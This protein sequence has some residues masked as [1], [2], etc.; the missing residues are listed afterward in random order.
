MAL[1]VELSTNFVTALSG[2]LDPDEIILDQ[3]K[4][5]PYLK[6][7][8]G[9]WHGK[10]AIMVLPNSTEKL[11]KIVTLC[12]EHQIAITCQG[13]NTGLVGGQIPQGEL[14][15]NTARMSAVRN[16]D[17][18]A[19]TI[20][21]EAGMTLQSVTD[22]CVEHNLLFAL[23]IASGGSATIGGAIATNAGGMGVLRYGNMRAMV[24]G[25]EVVM[26]D[27]KVWHGL[28]GLHKD[29]TGYDLKQLFI[30]S[31]GT[32]GVITAAILQLFPKP[33]NIITAWCGL[34]NVEAALQLLSHLRTNSFSQ[35]SKFELISKQALS[36]VLKNLSDS[37]APF[38]DAHAYN[39]LV[40]FETDE[41]V[42]IEE[43]LSLALEIGIITDAV[44]A[45][46]QKEA[47]A[48]LAL[49]ENIS[50]AQKPE[51]A[52]IKHDISLPLSAIPQF[53]Q[54]MQMVISDKFPGTRFCVFGHLGDGNLHYNLLQP[55]D[56]NGDE[57]L[58]ARDQI[59]SMVHDLVHEMGGSF[60]AEHGIGIAK[61]DDM[62][63]YK[64]PVGLKMM[65]AVKQA[66]DPDNIMNPRVIFK[67]PN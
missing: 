64:S 55:A 21:V 51:G 46:S 57:F 4:L 10:T 49:R 60:A 15:L 66:I 3:E 27:G 25:L 28:S 13:G 14:L 23:Q 52:A 54:Q 47:D 40:E 5:T 42:A 8:R 44:I 37:R 30:G 36:V 1:L 7:W 39:V 41:F 35:I 16:I 48:L 2:V 26:P 38:S 19:M 34:Q 9:R 33:A 18:K 63:R 58:S 62:Q 6:E 59:T 11:A 67:Q 24:L 20:T 22:I 43:A 45:K 65:R 31:E 50:A 32:L 17:P 61:I 12:A 29:N 56:V 53:L